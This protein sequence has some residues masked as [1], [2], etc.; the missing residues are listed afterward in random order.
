MDQFGVGLAH[1]HRDGRAAARGDAD[2][3]DVGIA[4][5]HRQ[6]RGQH[7]GHAAED[8]R[9]V[10]LHQLPG[11]AHRGRVA[12]AGRAQHHQ[13]AAAGQVGQALRQRAAHMEQRQ[14]AQDGAARD[15]QRQAQ[16]PGLVDLVGMAVAHQL[17]RAGGA[18]GV[19]VAGDVLRRDLPA[20]DQPVG[21]VAAQLLVEVVDALRFIG[22]A[23]DHQHRLQLRQ[24]ALDLLHLVPDVAARQRADGDQHL[25][26]GRAQDLAQLRR[27]QQRVHRVGDA[28][29]LRAE[30]AEVTLRQQRQQEADHV[31]RADA[32]A[33]KE[34]GRLRDLGKELGVAQG[35]RRLIGLGLGQELQR[36]CLRVALHAQ[37][38]RLVGALRGDA[39]VVGRRGLEGLDLGGGS[40]G[41]HRVADQAV[42]Q[43]GTCHGSSPAGCVPG[44][45][46]TAPMRQ[47]AA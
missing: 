1:G 21:R 13:R 15:R 2:A 33:G 40:E 31:L 12:P 28:R 7:R 16:R 47:R 10:A 30:Q 44:S 25:G 22:G 27:R 38:Q 37:A 39:L 35:Q 29:R 9:L 41:R 20:A 23:V 4:H 3:A 45:R 8:L 6:R 34:V 11:I 36:R 43:M 24:A 5:R 18:A 17:G 19:E 32:E 46:V 26:A 14:A 42:E